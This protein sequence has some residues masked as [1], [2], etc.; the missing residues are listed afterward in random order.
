MATSLKN[1]ITSNVG[2]TGNTVYNPT[3]SGI[4]STMIGLV[5][6]NTSQ[7]PVTANVTLTSGVNTVYIVKN[8]VIPVGNSLDIINSG[9]I[10]LT[11]GNIVNVASSLASSIDVTVSAVEVV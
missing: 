6:C 3:T 5:L 7:Y 8:M 9:K 2:L 11:Q 4:Q 10:I 1:Y